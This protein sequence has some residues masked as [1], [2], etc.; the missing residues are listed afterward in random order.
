MNKKLGAIHVHTE[1]SLNDSSM[2]IPECVKRVKELGMEVLGLTQHGN[3]L[4][5][6]TA[7]AECNVQGI[8]LMPG[9]EVYFSDD[10]VKPR[11]LIL[12]ALSFEGY[13]AICR[14]VTESNRNMINGRPV[15]TFEMLQ[16][17]VN[18]DIVITSACIGGLIASI[19]TEN[20]KLDEKIGKLQGKLY[21]MITTESKEYQEAL[22]LCLELDKK[23][24]EHIKQRDILDKKANKKYA[25]KLK[26]AE[27]NNNIKEI[28]NIR[29]EMEATE[30]AKKEAKKIRE[31]LVQLKKKNTKNNQ[32]LKDF[33]KE[34][35]KS[36]QIETQISELIS[37][38][39][40]EK[41][42]IVR[43]KEEIKHFQSLPSSFYM[44]VQYHNIDAER[45][46]FPLCV[47]IAKECHVPLIAT[48]DA[49]IAENTQ[50]AR[51]GR[52]IQRSLRFNK[53]EEEMQGDDELY[54]KTPDEI[55][56]MLCQIIS[57]EDAKEAVENLKT[58]CGL[59]HFEMKKELHFP[60]FLDRNRQHPDNTSKY[61]EEKCRKNISQKVG[62]A[63]NDT[64]ESRLQREL[65]TIEK[66]GFS[67]YLCIVL[68]FIEYAREKGISNPEGVGLVVGTGR[69]S[70]AGSLVCFLTGITTGIDPIKYNLLFERFLN[71]ER[72]SFPDIDTDFANFLRND[73]IDY[74]TSIYGEHAVCQIA[75]ENRQ[76]GKGAIR[77]AARI[78]GSKICIKRNL[79]G[80]QKDETEKKFLKIADSLC[81]RYPED[82]STPIQDL[83]TS[84]HTSEEKE[85]LK[86]ADS[87]CG[88]LSYTGV[89]AAGVIIS[90]NDDVSTHVPL[91]YDEK[92]NTWKT[93]C[94]MVQ[95]EEDHGL[96]KMDFLGL[97]TLDVITDCLRQI[98][99]NY[100]KSIQVENIPLDDKNIFHLMA[101]GNTVSVFQFESQGMQQTLKR[102]VPEKFE[103]LILLNAI[104]RPGPM[105]YID[106]VIAVHSGEKSPHYIAK[107]MSD[108]LDVTYGYPIYQEQIMQLLNKVAGFS[109]GE[110][111]IIR[112]YMSKK[113]TEKFLKY[114][115]KF[116][117]GMVKAGASQAD[118]KAYWDDLV[119]FS[120][121]AF[122]KSHAAA[123]TYLAYITAYLKYY[124]P[125]EY[126]SAQ[127]NIVEFDKIPGLYREAKRLGV[128]VLPININ[129]SSER[130]VSQNGTILFGFKGIKGL[131][132]NTI[133]TIL[134]TRK[135]QLFS[136]LKDFLL[137]TG[138][139][140][141]TELLI[142]SGAFDE[143][144][145]N[146]REAMLLALPDLLSEQDK[147][148]KRIKQ[149]HSEDGE[150]L[151]KSIDYIELHKQFFEEIEI[152]SFPDEK[153]KVLRKEAELLGVY[154]S[155]HP[156]D[157]YQT[158][159]YR[160][161]SQLAPS[162]RVRCIALIESVKVITTKNG[163]EMAFM[164]VSDT[165]G[166]L[167]VTVFPRQFNNL[168]NQL[169][170]GKVFIFS[171]KLEERA[172]YQ[173]DSVMELN[174][175]LDKIE[176]PNKLYGEILLEIP[177]MMEWNEVYESI[178][179]AMYLTKEGYKLYL[180]DALTKQI[181]TTSLIV[182]E[183]ILDNSQWNARF[184]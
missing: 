157:A 85:I 63:W 98:K 96:L 6:D 40:T 146:Q 28:E 71:E 162:P 50:K 5:M 170:S 39:R 114:E 116:I 73:V 150:K 155:G 77:N 154:V 89:H 43:A 119:D 52:Q 22:A 86:W 54:I 10:E 16:K 68:D 25:A 60:K 31:E 149:S 72:V 141:D 178:K 12:L 80:P 3:V 59:C 120:K 133:Q 110:A 62:T 56:K 92:Q 180:F 47:K 45:E 61:L 152:L 97:K 153:E 94:D 51:L 144:A 156:L 108:I 135:S 111:D 142:Q 100:N 101:Q 105:Q 35:D 159:S 115:P 8:Q 78:Y 151:K 37:K 106:D 30:Q 129:L 147:I 11:H 90:D 84:V 27:K 176:T 55:E 118:A 177:S 117:S 14:I 127:M 83:M 132:S 67:D 17:Y 134:E 167:D 168:K 182:N 76:V 32:R 7:I 165:T 48:N 58:V 57:P 15:V 20:S 160:S 18:R 121:Y 163:Q 103:D 126:L 24:S 13:Q 44:E 122:N 33:Q 19:F 4:G 26:K 123:Y 174:L 95:C 82:S 158:T 23:I 42:N 113:K 64:Y 91:M 128:K 107:G 53:Y 172:S 66:M 125:A 124:Y 171:G 136:S 88:L 69:G 143:I 139:K 137:R 164:T 179:K 87:V 104:Y 49:H 99:R 148:Q 2:T 9:C 21:G 79:S 169:V 102:F 38:K 65:K 175:I 130:F 74:V 181:R 184:C 166:T 41:E 29:K 34:L 145:P 109:L 131:A 161:L 112:R 183:S 173:D 1:Q 36:S 46:V 140:A 75:T 93:Q 138:I 70:A 81:K